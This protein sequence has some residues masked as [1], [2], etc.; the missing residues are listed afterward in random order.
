MQEGRKEERKVRRKEGIK[1]GRRSETFNICHRL[2]KLV[3]R[4][5]YSRS[6]N[7]FNYLAEQLITLLVLLMLKN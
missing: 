3:Q 4:F 7:G 2:L 1:E 6:K 5:V